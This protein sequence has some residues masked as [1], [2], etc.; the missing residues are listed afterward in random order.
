LHFFKSVWPSDLLKTPEA[1]EEK[2][3]AMEKNYLD[4]RN[5]QILINFPAMANTDDG[6][7]DFPRAAGPGLSLLF[8]DFGREF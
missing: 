3:V 5:L 4:C 6:D 1:D 8:F 2:T 7:H